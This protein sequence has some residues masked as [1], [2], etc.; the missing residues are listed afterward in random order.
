MEISPHK[1]RYLEYLKSEEW[2]N[3]KLE[4]IRI[5]GCKCEGCGAKK[6]PSEL[7]LHHLTYE[8]LFRELLEDLKLLCAW[9][10]GKAHKL[11]V[12][13]KRKRNG[14]NVNIVNERNKRG[15]YKTNKD[16]LIALK[17]AYRKD[18]LHKQNYG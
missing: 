11:P 2:L 8:R 9:C 7:E 1:K 15:R 12:K 6:K 16:Y 13:K 17:S 10:H 3:L 5:R 4:V 18:L 14:R